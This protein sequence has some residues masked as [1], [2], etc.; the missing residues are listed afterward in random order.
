MSLIIYSEGFNSACKNHDDHQKSVK[1]LYFATDF[2]INNI[3]VLTLDTSG[4][5]LN[6]SKL[7][8]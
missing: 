3:Q 1:I 7:Y 2:E 6:K 4:L 5:N 8:H